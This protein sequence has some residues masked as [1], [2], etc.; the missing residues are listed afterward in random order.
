MDIPR[1]HPADGPT[2]ACCGTIADMTTQQAGQRRLLALETSGRVGSVAAGSGPQPSIEQ[3]FSSDRK[4]AV[5]LLPT[6]KA[7]CDELGWEPASVTDLAIS[8]GPGSFTGLR[9]G[10]AVV[11]A[12]GQFSAV[13]GWPVRTL[14]VVSANLLPRGDR[15]LDVVAMLDAKRG[16]VYAAIC[17]CLSE[18]PPLVETRL[19][20][21]VYDPA[22][23]LARTHRPFVALGEAFGFLPGL[24]EAVQR[25]GGRVMDCE[26]WPARA[27]WVYRLAWPQLTSHRPPELGAVLPVYVRL[28]EAEERWRGKQADKSREARPD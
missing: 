25:A 18:Q 13:R 19:G 24:D 20:P 23:V 9:V 3:S 5:E 14:E 10:F 22:D 15:E 7:T 4:H 6:L 17:R 11:R 27:H 2:L 12:W 1:R 21:G 16:Q 28:P 26:L 8:A